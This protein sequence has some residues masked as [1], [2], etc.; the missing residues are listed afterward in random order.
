MKPL[1][2]ISRMTSY[3]KIIETYLKLLSNFH[4]ERKEF[5]AIL[6][7]EIE[8]IEYPNASTKSITVSRF[9]D[10]M[11]RMPAGKNLLKEQTFYIV[12]FLLHKKRITMN[13]NDSFESAL[14][15]SKSVSSFRF[16]F[17]RQKKIQ[18]IP[19]TALMQI[20][21]LTLEFSG[22]APSLNFK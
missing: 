10:L 6:P 1:F 9:E 15:I 20:Q 14:K 7:P 5:E 8:Q 17:G 16:P 4:L 12:W 3:K 18:K 22:F 19:E 2:E 21:N 11:R 13:S